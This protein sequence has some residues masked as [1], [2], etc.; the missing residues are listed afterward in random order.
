MGKSREA[1]ISGRPGPPGR[2]SHMGRT[3]TESRLYHVTIIREAQFTITLE[4]PSRADVI[5][6][7]TEKALDYDD[8]DLKS[9]QIVSIH[10]AP[11]HPVC[12]FPT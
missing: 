1:D 6:M 12:D 7:V 10:E 8:R 11:P 4:A 3:M 5:R 2:A 9:T